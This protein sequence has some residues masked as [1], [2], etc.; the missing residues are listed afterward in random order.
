MPPHIRCILST[1]CILTHSHSYAFKCIQMHSLTHAFT[2]VRRCIHSCMLTRVC[3]RLHSYVSV[4]IRLHS[5]AFV[6]ICMHLHAFSCLQLQKDPAQLRQLRGVVGRAAHLR[7]Q[8][9]DGLRQDGAVLVAHLGV[10]LLLEDV[11]IHN[12]ASE[13][14]TRWQP[15]SQIEC[16]TFKMHQAENVL[17]CVKM[18]HV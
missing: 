14:S 9:V 17:E 4:C 12:N 13:W 10:L 8:L 16:S 15:S 3:I 2:S 1:R 18:R 7:R 5:Y 11:R 6:C